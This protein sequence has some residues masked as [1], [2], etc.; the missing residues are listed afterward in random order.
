MEYY[1]MM[2]IGA[3][4]VNN[5]ILAQFLGVCP[6]MGV[7]GKMS[8]AVGM[9]AAIL[10]VMTLSTIATSL[11]QNYLLVPFGLQY[12]QTILFILVIAAL[13]QVLEII[14]KKVSP[15][16]YTALGIF[17]PLLTTN[18]AILGVAILVTIKEFT[19]IDA[20]L[21]TIFTASG[22]LI[23][24]VIFAGIREELELVDIPKGMKGMP[25]AL[26]TVGILAM[27]F[28]GFANLV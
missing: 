18:C 11:F 25:I 4:L 1:I 16:L 2:L 5:I 10:F 12:L 8:T 13:V 24:I 27:A 15:T 21:F 14:L 3:V 19:L 7:S 20:T 17:L 28:M 23:A 26:I 6:F 22:Y 9:G